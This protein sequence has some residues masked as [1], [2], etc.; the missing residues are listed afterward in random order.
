MSEHFLQQKY[1]S[2]SEN[3]IYLFWFLQI[4]FWSFVSLVSL[5]SLTLWYVQI[6][7][8]HLNHTF[9]QSIVG[10][11]FSLPL[12]WVFMRCWNTALFKRVTVSIVWVLFIS[13]AWTVVRV[14]LYVKLTNTDKTWAEFGGWYFS[15]IFIYFCW[16]GFFHGIRYYQLLQFEH[17]IMLKKEAEAKSEQLQRLSAQSVAR[18]AK[19]KMLRYQLNPHFLCNTL[20]AINSLIESELA[21]KAQLMTVQLS[22][23]LRYSLDNDPDTKIALEFEITALELYLE[24]EKTRFG[25][26]LQLD[27]QVSEAA[28]SAL[29]PSL[30][31]QP[32]IENS[33]KHVIAQNEEGGII[34]L[35]ADVIDDS[36]VLELSD[37]GC[38]IGVDSNKIKNKSGRGVGLRNIDERLKVLYTDNYEFNISVRTSGGLKT[39][40][41]LPLESQK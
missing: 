4:C 32:I 11:A 31:L 12:Y 20:N 22:K 33:M 13:F 25:E 19:I 7:V 28:K 35:Y 14:E 1:N 8:A 16:A 9:W 17:K 27:F 23:F 15:S 24:I 38:G 3:P 18:D 10:I 5:V 36:L 34:S 39:T 30:L 40:I 6:D 41:K 29:I 2:I 37:T 26:R 21:E